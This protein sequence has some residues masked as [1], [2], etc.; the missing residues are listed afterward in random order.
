VHPIIQSDADYERGVRFLIAKGV[1]PKVL[2]LA[3]EYRKTA[4]YCLPRHH[5]D[6]EA[7]VDWRVNVMLTVDKLQNRYDVV[8]HNPGLDNKQMYVDY[9]DRWLN[10]LRPDDAVMLRQQFD[11]SQPHE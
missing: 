1:R 3:A 6:P 8:H 7:S 5:H 2:M 4:N 11:E 10:V 9:F